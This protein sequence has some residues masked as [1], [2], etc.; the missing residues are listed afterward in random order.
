MISFL[1]KS[2]TKGVSLEKIKKSNILYIP[3]GDTEILLKEARRSRLIEAIKNYRKVIMGNS[4]GAI[5]LCKKGIG[6]RGERYVVYK[7]IGLANI[8]V[9]VHYKE[10]D[11]DFLQKTNEQVI[12][13]RE[14]DVLMV[15][16]N[17]LV[18]LR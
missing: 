10:V 4:A 8:T 16:G 6:K 15:K 3:G 17:Q 13:L 2:G 1:E 9:R 12:C 11:D 5:F 7:G 18:F 14:G